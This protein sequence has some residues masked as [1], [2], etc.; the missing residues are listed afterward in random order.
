MACQKNIQ[1]TIEASIEKTLLE[2]LGSV[3]A[4]VFKPVADK[5]VKYLNTLWDFDIMRS[6][7]YSSGG[8]YKVVTDAKKLELA[9]VKHYNIQLKA[10]ER[11]SKTL[12]FFNGDIALME[13]AQRED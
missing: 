2:K 8:G 10:E 13:Q 3:D 4:V 1:Q 5:T 6:Y 7:Q 9:A 12:P 11:F